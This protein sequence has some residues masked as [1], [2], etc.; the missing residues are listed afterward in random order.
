ME[1]HYI[2][3]TNGIDYLM[4]ASTVALWGTFI[5]LPSNTVF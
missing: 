1:G 2:N 4:N 3:E 5:I